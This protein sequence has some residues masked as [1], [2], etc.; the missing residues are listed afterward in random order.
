MTRFRQARAS[1]DAGVYA[2][3]YAVLV[4]ALFGVASFVVDLASLREG[5][6]QTRSAADSAVVAAAARLNAISPASS[7]PR[8]GCLDGWKYLRAGIHGLPDGSG[9]CTTL[10]T[11]GTSCSITT[12]PRTAQYT[13]PDGKWTVRFT[14]PVATNSRLMTEP[15]S[16]PADTSNRQSADPAFDGTDQ[17]R[18]FRIGVEVFHESDLGFSGI[19]GVSHAST[20]AASVGRNLEKGSTSDEVAALNVLEQTQCQVVTT[21]G[22]AK[23]TV[24][25]FG[26]RAGIIAVESSATDAGS[27]C[28]GASKAA[29]SPSQTGNNWIRANGPIG[30][31]GGGVIGSYAL[32]PSPKGR[33]AK[34]YVNVNRISPTPSLMTDRYGTKPVTDVFDCTAGCAPGGGNYITALKQLYGTPTTAPVG[35]TKVTA[36]VAPGFSCSMGPNAPTVTVPSGKWFVDCDTLSIS[37]KLIFR[38]GTIVT[39]GSIEV[40]SSGSCLAVNVSVCPPSVVPATATTPVTTL[41]APTGDALLYIGN[42][43][44]YKVA[45][46]GIYMPQTFTFLNN[47]WTE[48]GGGN[49]GGALFMTTP[50]ATA[51]GTDLA[52]AY[53]KFRKLVLW[54]ESSHDH[55][56]G[57]QGGLVLR[58]V[59]YTP[60]AKTNL[61]GQAGNTQT[62]A[63]FWTKSLDVTGQGEL[64]MSAD[65]ES[66][67]ARPV[68][69]VALIR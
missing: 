24:N 42:G 6:A 29:I 20:R 11:T 61:A 38:G 23:I 37:N 51:C 43:R 56:I 30:E 32:N 7:D 4:V 49:N 33:P 62:N 52:C 54:S 47:G 55:S 65:P 1:G 10:P 19:V 35:F 50:L 60:N 64:T 2:I 9:T 63:Q 58:G 53:A 46:A 13:S 25:G 57:G 41:P 16:A 44:L 31:V 18:C 14:W 34:A 21:S 36:A 69:G 8:A 12:A 48:L 5:R 67:V 45:Q 40:G 59:L 66:S 27:S 3:L 39:R 15:D 26:E 28:S 22:N 17:Q 68:A